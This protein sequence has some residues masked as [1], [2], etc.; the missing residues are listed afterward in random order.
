MEDSILDSIQL[1]MMKAWMDTA[2]LGATEVKLAR[3][4]REEFQAWQEIFRF[5]QK[6]GSSG[7]LPVP[8][9]E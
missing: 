9:A 2:E 1:K 7:V 8:S 6:H 3:L 5:Y 4:T